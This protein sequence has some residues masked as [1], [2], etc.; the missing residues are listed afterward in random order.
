[1]YIFISVYNL[2]LFYPRRC[3]SG[4]GAE[5]APVRGRHL[6]AV[7][8]SRLFSR[9]L[10]RDEAWGDLP[11]DGAGTWNLEFGTVRDVIPHI[12]P[13]AGL[14]HVFLSPGSVCWGCILRAWRAEPSSQIHTCPMEHLEWPAKAEQGKSGSAFLSRDRYRAY[15]S[16]IPLTYWKAREECSSSVQLCSVW[17][18]MSNFCNFGAHINY[19]WG[20]QLM[21]SGVGLFVYPPVIF[22]Q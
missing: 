6:P 8:P 10:L 21:G 12:Y 18:L 2:Y 22:T 14:E 5:A 9:R 17:C 7:R 3:P 13:T 1:M 19:F 16:C 20:F 4:P 15:L 11:Q